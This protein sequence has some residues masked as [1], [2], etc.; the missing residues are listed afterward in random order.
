MKGGEGPVPRRGFAS[1]RWRS[2][3]NNERE[4]RIMCWS[5]S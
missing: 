5:T 3:S 2:D 4:D 1:P